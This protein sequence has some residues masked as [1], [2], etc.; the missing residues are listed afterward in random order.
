MF[1][2]TFL[3]TASM[4]PTKERNLS[5]VLVTNGKENIL[6]DCG[7]GT[8]RQMKIAGL[9][10][11][12]ITKILISH[13]HAD[14]VLGLGGLIRYLGVNQFDG[15]LE[16]YGPKGIKNYFNNILNSSI[17]NDLIKYK[18]IELKDGILFDNGDFIVRAYKLNHTAECFGFSFK[19]ND[20]RKINIKYLKEFDLKQHPILGNLQKGKDIIWKG[21][22]IKARDA[23]LLV[24]GSKVSFVLDTAYCETAIK[25]AKNSDILIS[26]ATYS[27]EHSD[28][29]EMYKHLTSK[30]AAVIAK[31]SKSK[32]LI[33]THFSQRYKDTYILLKDARKIF[34]NV[35][36]SKDFMNIKI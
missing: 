13:W 33:L 15:V 10:P 24:K 31:K 14:H 22:K 8:Q 36:I 20:K 30:Q 16:I 35:K 11:T 18:L 29:A 4:Q 1:N 3:G 17:Y 9:K 2:I 23:T 28:K 12:K 26:E 19:E 32:N 5:S 34:K 21:K 6:V 25:L 7:E 27:D